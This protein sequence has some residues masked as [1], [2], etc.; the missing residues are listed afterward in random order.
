LPHATYI[1]RRRPIVGKLTKLAIR[2]RRRVRS[3]IKEK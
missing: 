2:L 1:L 3:R